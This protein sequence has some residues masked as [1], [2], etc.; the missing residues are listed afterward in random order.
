M[1]FLMILF[2]FLLSFGMFFFMK[3]DDSETTLLNSIG[4]ISTFMT[5]GFEFDDKEDRYDTAV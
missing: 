2:Y 4:K 5:G 3:A 1:V